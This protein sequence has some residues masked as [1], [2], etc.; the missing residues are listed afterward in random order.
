MKRTCRRGVPAANHRCRAA[1]R[2]AACSRAHESALPDASLFLA[3]RLLAV[4]HHAGDIYLLALYAIEPSTRSS[5]SSGSGPSINGSDSCG[6]ASCC[7]SSPAG[8]A[9]AAGGLAQARAWVSQLA[10]RVSGLAAGPAAECQENG[11]LVPGHGQVQEQQQQQQ[12]GAGG[13]PPFRLREGRARYLENVQACLQVRA[14]LRPSNHRQRALA[15]SRLTALHAALHALAA[16]ACM[17]GPGQS[18]NNAKR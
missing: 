13:P 2:C 8:V 1:L 17:Q 11:R 5:P 10:D 18:S 9:R 16:L 4:D 14:L 15:W 6:S 12:Q 3:D 7:G